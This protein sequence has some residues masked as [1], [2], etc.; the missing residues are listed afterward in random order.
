M[1]ERI[2]IPDDP[3]QQTTV[4][5][6]KLTHVIE[7]LLVKQSL[8]QFDAAVAAKRMI[9][10]DLYG[11]P[12]HGAGR[13]VDASAAI[14]IG[15]VDPRA[16]V[17]TVHETHVVTILDGSRALG[18]IAATKGIE[19]AIAKAK[20]SGV[21]ITSISNSQTLGAL[22]VYLRLAAEEG[23]IAI[24]MSSTG[25]ATV[26]APGS[27]VGTVGNAAFAYAIPRDQNPPI[28]FDTACGSASWAQLKLLH[29]F[30]VP[31]PE[32]IAFTSEGEPTAEMD[33]AK[34][35][36][37]TGGSLGF[38]LSLL[39]SI[40]AGPLSDGQ[41][42]I[43]KKRSDSGDDSQHFFIALNINQFTDPE[44]FHKRVELAIAEMKELDP[45]FQLP[46]ERGAASFLQRTQL[47]IPLHHTIAAEIRQ[48]AQSLNVE[49]GF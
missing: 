25:G 26:T 49:P 30:G 5:V 9:E 44:R 2:L 42:A 4:A 31:I 15:D 11:R 10:A 3:A 45:S 7:Q 21:G 18:Q 23:V 35:L 33:A 24:G 32:G 37:P 28:V 40:L 6:E 13:I 22:S 47:G 48:L 20:S 1:T 36:A 38:G 14:K 19:A 16:R 29:R 27:T 41:M 12:A 17:L 34:F 43:R 8:F 39:C 46:G